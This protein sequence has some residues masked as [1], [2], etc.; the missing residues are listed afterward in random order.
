MAR[1]NITNIVTKSALVPPFSL[2]SFLADFPLYSPP[3]FSHVSISAC[4]A[5]FAI[6]PSGAI[7]SYASRSLAEVAESRKQLSTF[8]SFFYPDLNLAERYAITNVVA[9]V[10]IAP[11]YLDLVKLAMYLPNCSYD[12]SIP[13]SDKDAYEHLVNCIIF[14]FYE[15]ETKPRYTALIFPSGK[16][17]FTG[18]K[19]IDELESYALKFSDIVSEISLDHPEVLSHR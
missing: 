18:F 13:M 17:T 5:I 1:I 9:S 6:F 19:S 15:D 10:D 3:P 16:V 12:P 8:F 4:H 11:P 14:Y 2:S 7:V